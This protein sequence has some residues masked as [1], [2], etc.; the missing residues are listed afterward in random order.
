MR[1]NVEQA[2]L[3]VLGK[4]NFCTLVD[5]PHKMVLA[6]LMWLQP[7]GEGSEPFPKALFQGAWDLA[8]LR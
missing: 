7:T 5:P 8:N 4:L 3:V 6:F 2:E 1:S